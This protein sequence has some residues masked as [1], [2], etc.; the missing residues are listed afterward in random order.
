MS[1]LGHRAREFPS[2]IRFRPNETLT[3]F[4]LHRLESNNTRDVSY[5]LLS[6]SFG[7]KLAA[8]PVRGERILIPDQ[9]SY[10]ALPDEPIQCV[11][12]SDR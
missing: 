12:G 11:L 4:I 9:G 5:R 7:L 10:E 8:Y 2:E 1:N 6:L 3:R